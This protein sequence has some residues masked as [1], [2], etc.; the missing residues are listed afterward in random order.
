MPTDQEINAAIATAD[1]ARH[2]G[3]DTHAMKVL[4]QAVRD[5]RRD[6]PMDSPRTA[7]IYQRGWD[8]A[9]MRYG[10]EVERLNELINSPETDEFLQGVQREMAHQ[11]ERWGKPHDREKSA[12][13]W[14]WLV[15]YL[16]G[17]ALRAAM[18]GNKEKALH[19][20]ISSAAALGHWHQAIKEDTTGSGEGRDADLEVFETG[21]QAHETAS[22]LEPCTCLTDEQIGLCNKDCDRDEVQQPQGE[23]IFEGSILCDLPRGPRG[24]S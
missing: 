15:G 11:V 24:P 3:P 10:R 9:A 2:L 22:I 12:E 5:F 17:K 1:F 20:C 18:F 6:L 8:D 21:R 14:F 4:A 16:A 19:H 23:R 7:T 13:H